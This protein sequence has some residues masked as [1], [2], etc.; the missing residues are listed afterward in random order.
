MRNSVNGVIH[1][2][3]PTIY[4]GVTHTDVRLV[5][6]DGKIIEATSSDTEKLNEVFDTDEGARTSANSPSAS[7]PIAPSR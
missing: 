6:K 4:R 1:Y 5:F 2:N 3:C 7:T